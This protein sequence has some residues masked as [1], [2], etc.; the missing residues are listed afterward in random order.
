MS[1]SRSASVRYR[2]GMRGQATNLSRR[3]ARITAS[4]ICF[5]WRKFL[6]VS[7][8]VTTDERLGTTDV[9]AGGG[10]GDGGGGGSSPSCVAEAMAERLKLVIP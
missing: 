3:V 8:V 7:L 10:G 4:K 6:S 1:Q 9:R 2:G 5:Q